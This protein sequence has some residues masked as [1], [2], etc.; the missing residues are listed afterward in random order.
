MRP[1]R[2][3]RSTRDY[4]RLYSSGRR[5]SLD[6]LTLYVAPRPDRA[7]P[8]RLGLTVKGRSLPAVVRNR[9]KRRLRAAFDRC[10]VAGVDVV[11][12]G[13]QR[14]ASLPF[15]QLVE[16]LCGGIQAALGG[17]A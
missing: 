4:E 7:S 11:V 3:L 15:Q 5:L 10:G 16:R 6:G 1:D 14:V 2:S 17:A 8:A 9:I 12:R 13:E